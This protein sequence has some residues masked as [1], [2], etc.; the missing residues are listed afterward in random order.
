MGDVYLYRRHARHLSDCDAGELSRGPVSVFSSSTLTRV[1]G[2]ARTSRKGFGGRLYRDGLAVTRREVAQGRGGTFPRRSWPGPG[3]ISIWID[4]GMATG[5][6]ADVSHRW[7][8][9]PR[10]GGAVRRQNPS[11]SKLPYLGGRSFGD[12]GPRNLRHAARAPRP[13]PPPYQSAADSGV[14]K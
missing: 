9:T 6:I 5:Q 2:A 12:R 8:I 1:L 14:L 11:K 3:P 10:R 4:V 13:S 7:L